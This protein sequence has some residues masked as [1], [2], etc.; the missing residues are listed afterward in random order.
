MRIVRAEAEAAVFLSEQPMTLNFAVSARVRGPLTLEGLTA[1]L[2]RLG[3]RHPLLAV[4]AVPAAD[5]TAYFTDEGVPPIAVRIVERVSDDDWVGEAERDTQRKSAYL[6]EPMIRCIWVRGQ[7]SSDLVL[8]CDHIVADGRSAIFALRDLL[9][10]IADPEMAVEPLLAPPMPELVPAATIERIKAAF[11][12]A[13][14]TPAATPGHSGPTAGEPAPPPDRPVRLPSAAGPVCI[15][16]F[17]L[18]A[19][20][21]ATLLARCRSERVTVQSAICAAFLTPFAEREPDRPVRHAEIPVDLRPRLSRPVGDSYG[22]MIGLNVIEVDC[23]PGGNLWDVA[24]RASAALAAMRDEDLFATVQVQFALFGRTRR[25]PWQIDYDLSISNLGRIEI[26]AEYGDFRLESIY[27]PIFPATGAEHRILGISTFGGRLRGTFSSR[28]QAA[29][30]L[31]ARGLEL[32]RSM[33]A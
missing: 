2:A 14:E 18:T 10:L 6:T 27:G 8:V 25:T 31:M 24:R 26:P 29:A 12:A 9:E 17:D 1:A 3:E 23:A 33:V 21:T 4:R 11:A 7:D 13:D 30:P 20:E 5:G 15:V 22:N 28:G 16:P 32:L 19:A